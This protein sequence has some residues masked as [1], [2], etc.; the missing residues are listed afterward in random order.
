[1]NNFTSSTHYGEI[2]G[3]ITMDQQFDRG[4]YKIASD[5][6][7]NTAV[8]VPIAFDFRI[9]ERGHGSLSIYTVDITDY[10]IAKELID[11]NDPIPVKKVNVNISVTDFF[12]HF[13]QISITASRMKGVIGRD[14][15]II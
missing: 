2:K 9:L 14:Y 7:V 8:N 13:K 3:N 12:K 15:T 6:G 5:Y 11:G 10:D 1:M 4:I